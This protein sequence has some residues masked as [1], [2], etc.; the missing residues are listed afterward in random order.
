LDD[1]QFARNTW[2]SRNRLRGNDKEKRLDIGIKKAPLS[3]HI[4]DIE[5]DKKSDWSDIHLDH[6]KTVYKNYSYFNEGFQFYHSHLTHLPDRL[7]DLTCA[8]IIDAAKLLGIKTHILRAHT[9]G[10]TSGRSARLVDMCQKLGAC[11]YLSPLGS[12][13]YITHDA[14][15]TQHV[16]VHYQTY[17]PT[18]YKQSFENETETFLPYL[19]FLDAVMA[20]G[21]E[22]TGQFIH[23]CAPYGFETYLRK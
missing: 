7:S 3:S 5:I 4:L 19:G 2:Q 9:L 10:A 14:Q 11:D 20:M 6:V 13:D 8:M 23:T 21:F 17:R 18:A 16:R 12:K 22:A 15:L 1:V